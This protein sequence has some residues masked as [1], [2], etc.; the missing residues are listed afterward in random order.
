MM[1]KEGAIISAN[2]LVLSSKGLRQHEKNSYNGKKERNKTKQDKQDTA[3]I[4]E[5]EGKDCTRG[6]QPVTSCNGKADGFCRGI[7]E[8]E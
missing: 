3:G 2:V 7:I 6:G 1:K 4:I 8:M 5:T